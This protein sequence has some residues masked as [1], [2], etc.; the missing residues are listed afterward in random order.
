[1]DWQSINIALSA[2]T[3]LISV[4]LALIVWRRR[5]ESGALWFVWLLS[6][7]AWVAFFYILE[8][9]ADTNLNAFVTFSKF[10]YVGLAMLPVLWFGFALRFSGRERIFNQSVFAPL[11]II[12]IIT[13][14]LAFT[15]EWHGAIW[16]EPRFV[17]IDGYPVYAPDYGA[18]FWVYGVYSYI[19][20][21]AGSVVLVH[22]SIGLW[23]LYRAQAL[24]ALIGTGLPWVS[25][26]LLIFDELNPFPFLQLN[27]LCLGLAMV[28]MAF[29]LFRLHL[30]DIA[31]LAYDT[32]LNNVPNNIIVVD[33]QNR[34]VALNHNVRQYLDD[35]KR[36]PIGKDLVAAFSQYAEYVK[37]LGEQQ[38]PYGELS[39]L[40]NVIEYRIV[41]VLD[42]RNRSRGRLF[43]LTD[44]TERANME[45][46]LAA[47]H[48]ELVGLYERVSQLEQLK[49]H[50][51]RVA[52][53]DL[54]NPLSVILSYLDMLQ[55]NP[56]TMD[57][58]RPRIYASM[59]RSAE[60]MEKIINEVLS[61]EHI[62][63]IVQ[64]LTSVP[65]DL[66]ERVSIAIEDF[67]M[68][69]EAKGLHLYT[70]VLD[71]STC[72][73]TGDEIQLFE[74]ISNFLSNAIKYTPAGGRIDVRLTCDGENARFEVVDTGFGIPA[75]Q[76]PNLFQ[77]F[78]RAKTTETRDIEGS[79]LGLFLTKSIIERQG[80]TLIFHSEY[81][82]GSTFGF[83]MPLTRMASEPEMSPA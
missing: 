65:F 37:P 46:A 50:M 63:K 40:G 49:T 2:F 8:I 19:V 60:R 66:G 52:A 28:C 53:H 21:F 29:A 30:L 75:E 45:K 77:A 64:N 48:E 3:T 62:E 39:V 31:P 24:L 5:H 41:P 58:D 14:L 43:V 20:F 42:R 12:P 83:T 67:E 27:A 22:R 6:A 44:M 51:I 78:F 36:D 74:A 26:I 56:E 76:Q 25:N 10:E 32:I 73:V 71:D 1:M 81:G 59:I 9:S 38:K 54:K 61:L 7:V 16:I 80:G 13:I 47:R 18:W 23:R 15:N 82:K 11:T 55:A 79:G 70:D 68:Q 34:I 72:W 17:I 35:P 69:A 4:L 57:I 33:D